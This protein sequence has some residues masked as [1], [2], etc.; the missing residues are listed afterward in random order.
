MRIASQM[1]ANCSAPRCGQLRRRSRSV[2]TYVTCFVDNPG[3]GGQQ[4]EATSLDE[5]VVSPNSVEMN[6]FSFSAAQS[7][8]LPEL[9][10]H[11]AAL[12]RKEHRLDG[13]APMSL[14]V[15]DKFGLFV[16]ICTILISVQCFVP[17]GL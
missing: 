13:Q 17:R 3:E 2:S 4:A 15:T 5:M 9:E 7:L 6:S 8:S 10:Q 12:T 11:S 1:Q 16:S 14:A